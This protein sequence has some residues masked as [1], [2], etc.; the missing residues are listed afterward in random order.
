VSWFGRYRQT[1]WFEAD[2]PARVEGAL[3]AVG[4]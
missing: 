3:A 4:A 1:V 2:D